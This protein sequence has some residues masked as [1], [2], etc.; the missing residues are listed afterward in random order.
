MINITIISVGK[1][2]EKYFVDMTN[3]YKKRITKFANINEIILE[4]ES[5]K[6]EEKKVLEIEGKRILEAIKENN[7]V[8]LL[9]LKGKMLDSVNFAKEIDKISTYNSSNITFI[10]GGSYGVSDEIKKRANYRLKISDM[11][12]PHQLAK[13][14]LLEQIYR[15]FTILNNV[16]Y[17]K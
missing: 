8:I 7:F 5:N 14:I 16:T 13:C 9:D 11:T 12:F 2:K 17:H 3:E 4:D 15:A 6:I 10:I 1:F